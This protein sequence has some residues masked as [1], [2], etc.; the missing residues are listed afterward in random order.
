MMIVIGVIPARY[1]S[2]RFPGKPLAMI[3][4]KT[5][6]ERVY[7]QA[8]RADLEK[9]IVATDDRRILEAVQSF[10]GT[11]VMTGDHPS[12]TDRVGEAVRDERCDFVINIQGDEPLIDPGVINSVAYAL[13]ENG[14]ADA[15]TAATKIS[16]AEDIDNPNIVKSVFAK[17]GRALYFS[18]SRIPY[19]RDHGAVYYKHI[20]IYGY[21]KKFLKRFVSLSRSSLESA[22][23]LEQLRMLE[24][25]YSMHVSVVAYDSISVDVPED[26]QRIVALLNKKSDI[27]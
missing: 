20:G 11:A 25:G 1:G 19:D 18:R 24:N 6:I 12:G 4:G 15:S 22:E 13:R 17:N 5:L 16:R 7:R 2:V 21:R 23:S 3:A 14:W 10:G 27:L 9:V 26:V 8:L